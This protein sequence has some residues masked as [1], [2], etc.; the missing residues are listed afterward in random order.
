MFTGLLPASIPAMPDP[1]LAELTARGL[2]PPAQAAAMAEADRTRPFSV[3]YELRALLY[4]G[5]VLLSGGLGVL[6]YQNV[7]SIGHGALMTAVAL[8]MGACFYFA[9]QHRP[10]FTWGEAPRTSIGADYLLLLGCLLFVAL[11]TYAQYHYGVFGTR[12]GLATALPAGLFIFLAYRYDHRGVLGLGLTALA[13]WAGL[14]AQPLA[15]FSSNDFATPAVRTAAIGL[16]LALTVA[17]LHAEARGRKAHFAFSYLLLGVNLAQ[18]ALCATMLETSGFGAWGAALLL[19]AVA[20]YAEP[21]VTAAA[22]ATALVLLLDLLLITAWGL[23][24]LPFALMGFGA[25]A[26]ALHQR[27]RTRIDADYYELALLVLKM[28][29]LVTVYASGNYLVVREASASLHNLLFS[30]QI[31]LA[32]LFYGFTAGI[33]LLYLALG[34]RRHDRVF[35][36][37]GLLTLAFSLFTLRHYRALLPP[38]WA[39]TLGGFLL[40]AGAGAALRYLRPQ[41]HGLTSAPDGEP[42]FVGLETLVTV[43]TAN[44]TTGPAAPGFEFGGGQSGGG[45]ATGQF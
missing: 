35:L 17:G 6:I 16:G 1:Y 9:A 13:S 3:H 26:H 7:N 31:A 40:V 22:Y 38:E 41:R 34:L 25:A 29:A 27:L 36:L 43:E 28:L 32:P 15:V 30:E 45:G 19:A 11:E 39:A 5:I 18:L 8:L 23:L 44:T 33:P 2:L 14:A 42:R 37:L 24:V 4:L 20:R 21:L 10:A 12:Y